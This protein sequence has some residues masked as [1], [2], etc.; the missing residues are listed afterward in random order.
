MHQSPDVVEAR[1][2]LL[3]ALLSH[4]SNAISAAR[5][6]LFSAYTIAEEGFIDTQVN[7][8]ESASFSQKH[9]LAWR[10]LN[11]VTGRKADSEPV[12]LD[13]TVEDRKEKWKDHF[14]KLLGQ[15]PKVP[16][17]PFEISSINPHTLPINEGHFT[18]QEL[19]KAINSTKRGGAVG[20]DC[21]P[22]EIW[23]SPQFLPY[24]LELCNIGY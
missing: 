8:I 16:D 5:D 10:V 14:V 7:I 20:V 18:L 1:D 2:N 21:I 22:L 3:K 17:G 12:R 6:N 19:M 4:D 13:G 23:E 15:P 24:L 11:E 9:A